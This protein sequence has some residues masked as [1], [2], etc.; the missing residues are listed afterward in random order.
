[1]W[2]SKSPGSIIQQESSRTANSERQYT[3]LPFC[4]RLQLR[5]KVSLCVELC[6]C[7]WFPECF[8]NLLMAPDSHRLF[9]TGDLRIALPFYFVLLF[10]Y[11][12]F[13]LPFLLCFIWALFT[14]FLEPSLL[15]YCVSLIQQCCLPPPGKRKAHSMERG[16]KGHRSD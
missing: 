4:S 2:E 13:A 16:N 10:I 1:M 15:T 7:F 6:T 8:S 11:F 14:N 12:I 9:P 5:C 3:V